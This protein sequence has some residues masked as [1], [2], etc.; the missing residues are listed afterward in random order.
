MKID[1][2]IF[3]LWIM[4][5]SVLLLGTR[6]IFQKTVGVTI[7]FSDPNGISALEYSQDKGVTWNTI[8]INENTCFKGIDPSGKESEMKCYEE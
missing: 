3:V 2:L 8:L 7:D 4:I 1:K 5:T 6:N